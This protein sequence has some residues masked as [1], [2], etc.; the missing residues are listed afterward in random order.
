MKSKKYELN[1]EDGKKI[2][3][4]AG[5]ALGGAALVYGA[6][7]LAQVDFGA[8]TELVVAVGA[9]AINAARQW[10]KDHK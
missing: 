4:G 3:K 10:L 5:I 8:Y 7:V 6:E 2:A 1:L 9:I